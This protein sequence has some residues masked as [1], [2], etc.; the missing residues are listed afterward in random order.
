[1]N[2]LIII[3]AFVLA[4]LLLFAFLPPK[5]AYRAARCFKL[6]AGVFPL[7]KI[8]DALIVYFNRIKH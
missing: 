6:V 3:F 5:R 1:M 8:C 7:S 4:I 2:N